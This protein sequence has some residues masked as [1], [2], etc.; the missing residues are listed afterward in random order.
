MRVRQQYSRTADDVPAFDP[1]KLTLQEGICR[2][3]NK[4][5]RLMELEWEMMSNLRR[6]SLLDCEVRG[7]QAS[8]QW[9]KLTAERGGTDLMVSRVHGHQVDQAGP[10]DPAAKPERE[11]QQSQPSSSPDLE[12]PMVG[13]HHCSRNGTAQSWK[14]KRNTVGLGRAGELKQRSSSEKEVTRE[15]NQIPSRL[16][17]DETE[18]GF[19]RA[20]RA[21]G[22]RESRGGGSSGSEIRRAAAA[23][24]GVPGRKD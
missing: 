8:R 11:E 2:P 14:R 23:S 9:R 12:V 4:T 22:R 13:D 15:E 5:I 16:C 17:G 21:S 7:F 18:A 3:L 24:G 6:R 10:V 1:V 20:R 19:C